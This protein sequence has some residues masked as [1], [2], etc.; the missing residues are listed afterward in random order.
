M[1]TS[2]ELTIL[3]VGHGKCVVLQ[4]EKGTFIFDAGGGSALL[5]F[6]SE[7]GVDQIDG[8]VISHADAD[9]ISGLSS[10]LAAPDIQ[11]DRIY[12]NPDSIKDTDA[13]WDL[14]YS[15]E[16]ATNRGETKIIIGVTPETTEGLERGDIKIEILADVRQYGRCDIE[17]YFG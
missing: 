9:H 12:I 10:L 13:W 14:R 17:R 5:E 11:V 1:T 7:K 8:I 16:D 15:V 6:L 4:D 2:P 3:D